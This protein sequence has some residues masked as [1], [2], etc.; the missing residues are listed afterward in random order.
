MARVHGLLARPLTNKLGGTP[1]ISKHFASTAV[2]RKGGFYNW[3]AVAW[4][5]WKLSKGRLSLWVAASAVPGY[6]I[7]AAAME[8]LTLTGLFVGTLMA[9]AAANALN[10]IYEAPRDSLMGRTSKRPLVNKEVSPTQARNFA[11][12]CAAGGTALL[13][14]TCNPVTAVL[15]AGN[16]ALYA[17]VYTPLKVLTPFNTHVGSIVGAVPPVMGC[18]A[19]GL[20][21]LSGEALALFVIQTLWQFPHFYALAWMYR[22][23]YIAGGFKMFPLHDDDGIETA[24]M[25]EPYLGSLLLLPAVTSAA[26]V[27]GWMFFVYSLVPSAFVWHALFKFKKAPSRALM[28]NFFLHS[29]WSLFAVYVLFVL[30]STYYNR[31]RQLDWSWLADTCAHEFLQSRKLAQN[32][33]PV[34]HM[35]KIGLIDQQLRLRSMPHR[36]KH[37]Y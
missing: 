27:T 24:K 21:I 33:C 9:S 7:G 17:G 25:M 13:A 35:S 12:G 10:Q 37:E 5:Y 28:R 3:E 20:S 36:K 8:P 16:I 1:F 11:I 18:A 29:L 30:H 15:G 14:L 2:G 31:K 19:A 23:D 6:I 26:G 22:K 32:L 34:S 4:S